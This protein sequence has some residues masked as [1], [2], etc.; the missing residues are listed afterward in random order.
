MSRNGIRSSDDETFEALLHELNICVDD[1]L[2]SE[3]FLKFRGNFF[4]H[5]DPR[6]VNVLIRLVIQN[7]SLCEHSL[8]FFFQ[9]FKLFKDLHI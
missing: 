7:L 5:S 2:I 6:A 8:G 3:L 9:K 1:G 4:I